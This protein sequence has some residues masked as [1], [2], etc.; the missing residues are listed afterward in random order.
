MSRTLILVFT[1]MIALVALTN[2]LS[3]QVKIK[4]S[5]TKKLTCKGYITFVAL[6]SDCG[7]CLYGVHDLTYATVECKTLAGASNC[8]KSV[9]NKW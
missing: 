7:E 9:V 1:V 4:A 8:C 3:V 2:A 5:G 6:D